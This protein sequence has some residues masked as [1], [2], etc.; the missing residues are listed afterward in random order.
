MQFYDLPLDVN[1]G[2]KCSYETADSFLVYLYDTSEGNLTGGKCNIT[3]K[4]R[5]TKYYLLQALQT[6]LVNCL[7]LQS[8]TLEYPQHRMCQ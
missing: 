2:F 1:G 5:T 3:F 7:T 4:A 8:I 6:Q